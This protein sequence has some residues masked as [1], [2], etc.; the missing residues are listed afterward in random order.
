M[1]WLR[2]EYRFTCS[3]FHHFFVCIC[4]M[5]S[6]HYFVSANKIWLNS[7]TRCVLNFTVIR[8]SLQKCSE[9]LK[10]QFTV[11]VSPVSRALELMEARKNLQPSR[12]DLNLVNFLL[13]KAFQQKLYRQD[14][15]DDDHLKQ[16]L[17][18]CWVR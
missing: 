7:I 13:R 16:V 2:H 14:F 1:S 17:I 12:S 9:M 15:R 11:Q 18:H 3:I 8:Y 5:N 6:K 4:W 10:R